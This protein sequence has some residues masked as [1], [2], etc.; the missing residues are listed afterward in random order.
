[1]VITRMTDWIGSTPLL[2]LGCR[3]NAWRLYLKLEKF[4]PG[5]S[6]KDRM[7]WGMVEAAER[8]GRLRPGGTIVESS[9]GNT[10]TGLALVAAERGYRF[11]AVV[12]HH[13]AAD[14]I[15]A[16][17]A[18]GAG[19]VRV[20]EDAP[21][22]SVA[23]AEREARA[24]ELASEIPGAV[25]MRQHD[26]AANPASYV[27]SLA[28]DLTQDLGRIDVLVGSVGTGGSLCGTASGLRAASPEL[29]VIGVE[30]RG[31]VVFGGPGGSY[32]QSGTGVPPGVEVG[33]TVD[34]DVI[35]QGVTVDDVAAFNACRFLAH[36]FGVVVGGSAGGVVYVAAA[37]LRELDGR[38]TMVA[39]MADGGEK[40]LDTIFDDAWMA[41]ACLLDL[42]VEGDLGA[43][44]RPSSRAVG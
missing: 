17:Q 27:D 39:L 25:V 30:P 8:R 13:A 14:K 37:R 31:S 10:G 32:Y 22:D 6:M 44:L 42:T 24:V 36:R 28:R 18:M 7:A 29:E 43:V 26:N 2:E 11:I 4:N 19:I 16:M 12:D 21:A 15:R 38:G 20:G 9:S 1:M 40:Y 33:S 3:A 23:T 34:Y 35:D 41:R 5:G